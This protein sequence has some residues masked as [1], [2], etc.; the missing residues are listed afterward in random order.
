MSSTD[1]NG[2]ELV[3]NQFVM[4]LW[5]VL[6]S[7]GLGAVLY[8]LV[9]L[10]R[11]FYASQSPVPNVS[12]G[13]IELVPVIRENFLFVHGESE[14]MIC[15]EEFAP[16]VVLA[17]TICGHAFHLY[18]LRRWNANSCPVCRSNLV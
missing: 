18:C 4:L 6:A 9:R 14:C 13:D 17:D 11:M 8:C 16:N 15:L 1:S 2:S 3:E 7:I 12:T 5:L 10:I